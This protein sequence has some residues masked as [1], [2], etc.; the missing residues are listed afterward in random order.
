MWI[1]VKA[2]SWAGGELGSFNILSWCKQ[3][4]LERQMWE[5]LDGLKVS[6]DYT[7]SVEINFRLHL[8][9]HIQ[10][11][12]LHANDCPDTIWILIQDVPAC[13][14]CDR[15]KIYLSNCNWLKTDTSTLGASNNHRNLSLKILHI[16][17]KKKQQKKVRQQI[18][19][20]A[21]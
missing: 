18:E 15:K 2:V 7:A 11:F 1:F 16:R 8:V 5:S 6:R 17:K 3:V 14:V 12:P 9:N 13:P 4:F 20:A 10:A 21:I 19:T